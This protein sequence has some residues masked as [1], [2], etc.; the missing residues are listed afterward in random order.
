MF[1]VDPSSR[2]GGESGSGRRGRGRRSAA[3][4]AAAAAGLLSALDGRPLR[5]RGRP[6]PARLL[7]RPLAPRAARL[8]RRRERLDARGA[9]AALVTNANG[10]TD[11]RAHRASPPRLRGSRPSP[12]GT[13]L[14]PRPSAPPGRPCSGFAF[15]NE[16]RRRRVT[17]PQR[18]PPSPR[19]AV[20][21]CSAR[22]AQR[23]T[24]NDR[25]E[26]T[27]KVELA[28]VCVSA[29]RGVTARGTTAAR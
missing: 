4:A 5:P 26:T 21:A 8:R 18:E 10:R 15:A 17:L 13:C 3:A 29:R 14:A 12:L 16:R 2:G 19:G 7:R 24:D 20:V 6:R 9:A 1:A 11:G 27:A 23:T 25:A 28:I 22:V